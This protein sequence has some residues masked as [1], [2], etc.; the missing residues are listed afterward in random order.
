M[1][2]KNA[3]TGS[4]YDNIG[5]RVNSDTSNIYR[6]YGIN[7]D[8]SVGYSASIFTQ[9]VQ[10]TT[11]MNIGAMSG[12][13]GSQVSGFVRLEGCNS[14]GIKMF[15]SAAGA[16]AEGSNSQQLRTLG[17]FVDTSSVISSITFLSQDV[18]N[19]DVGTLRIYGSVA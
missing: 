9:N 7:I 19:F 17:G 4:A 6:G 10:E 8:A 13:G 5:F 14:S 16:S 1:I 11:R 12:A 15:H 3:S 18:S 2:V